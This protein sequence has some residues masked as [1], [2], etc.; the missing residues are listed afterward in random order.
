[1][2]SGRRL[3]L[4]LRKDDLRVLRG[5]HEDKTS[6]KLTTHRMGQVFSQEIIK[7][8]KEYKSSQ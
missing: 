2:Q 3:V 4:P 1:M 7:A 6:M 5:S 8:N